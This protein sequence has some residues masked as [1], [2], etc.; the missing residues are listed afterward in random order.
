MLG[1]VCSEH[2]VLQTGSAYIVGQLTAR[3]EPLPVGQV[4]NESAIA[5]AGFCPC[6]E[7]KQ[8]LTGSAEAVS[9]TCPTNCLAMLM[10]V[11]ESEVRTKLLALVYVG[12][13][14]TNSTSE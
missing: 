14:P 11:L 4:T 7:A 2:A 5:I 13:A 1:S 9:P 10:P 6:S 8:I 3:H 12:L